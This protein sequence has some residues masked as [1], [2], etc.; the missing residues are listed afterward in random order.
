MCGGSGVCGRRGV[1]SGG[2]G[3]S[4]CLWHRNTLASLS[5]LDKRWLTRCGLFFKAKNL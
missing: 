3:G 4:V 2:G 5:D 1:C